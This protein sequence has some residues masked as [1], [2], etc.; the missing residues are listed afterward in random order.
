MASVLHAEPVDV[1]IRHDVVQARL[2]RI[3]AVNG[4]VNW[5]DMSDTQLT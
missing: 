5:H 1:C 4:G 2:V 3:V